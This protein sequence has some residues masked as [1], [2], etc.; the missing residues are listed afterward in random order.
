MSHT[1]MC[2]RRNISLRCL[3]DYFAS[4]LKDYSQLLLY[5]LLSL[6]YSSACQ[7]VLCT[8]YSRKNKHG[9]T[10][11]CQQQV[12]KFFESLAVCKIVKLRHARS[13]LHFVYVPK[14]SRAPSSLRNT[15]NICEYSVF[16][17]NDD[18]VVETLA[19]CLTLLRTAHYTSVLNGES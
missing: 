8:S 13:Y 3:P 2:D 18:A 10:F 5:M 12:R 16:V 11:Q 17:F 6:S 19:S 14:V 9:K 15:R 1:C 4:S 7:M